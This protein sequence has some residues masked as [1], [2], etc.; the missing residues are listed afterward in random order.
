M[1]CCNLEKW[2][3][4]NKVLLW[5]IASFVFKMSSGVQITNYMIQ[6]TCMN[7]KKVFNTSF[8]ITSS[9]KAEAT[10][11]EAWLNWSFGWF[12]TQA[13]PIKICKIKL[14]NNILIQTPLSKRFNYPKDH[15][16]YWSKTL[17]L[18]KKSS[19]RTSLEQS[20]NKQG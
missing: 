2:S 14:L 18:E 3:Q 6:L 19:K 16:M 5:L 13:H 1:K 11:Y 15:Q 20:H 10:P 7:N 4:F 8:R 17:Y 9:Q 12:D